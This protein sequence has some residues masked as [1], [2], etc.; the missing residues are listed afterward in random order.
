M[1]K[2]RAGDALFDITPSL[3][4]WNG[5]PEQPVTSFGSSAGQMDIDLAGA[6]CQMVILGHAPEAAPRGLPDALSDMGRVAG[7][8]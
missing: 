6:S 1:T 4:P 2:L 7:L 8:R 3:G 5:V